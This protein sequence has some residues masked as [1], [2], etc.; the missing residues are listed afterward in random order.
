MYHSPTTLPSLQV[1]TDKKGKDSDHNVVVFAPIS[2]ELYT[3]DRVKKTIR[4]RPVME[5]QILKF[6]QDLA[7]V[8]WNELF[9]NKTVD[10]QTELFHGFLR[11]NLDRYFPE[12]VVKISSMDK[13]WMTP[14]LKQLHRKM[15]REYYH[16]RRSPKYKKLKAKFKKMKRKSIKT[17]YADFVTE[18]KTTDPGK[19]YSMAKRIGAVDQMHN[20]DVR[21]ESLSNLTNNQSAQIIA[22]HFASISQEY[23]PIDNS[24]V[25]LQ[26]DLT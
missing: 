6:E 11:E 12:K 2:N 22:E 19:W 1:D 14:N 7:Q 4:T 13:K 9:E 18:L 24:G 15:Q 25:V 16:K 3:V 23:S 21:V 20:G 17:F 5:S 10:E 26:A 8:P